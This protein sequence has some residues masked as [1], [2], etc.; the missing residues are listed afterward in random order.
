M[1]ANSEPN[2]YLVRTLTDLVEKGVVGVG[3]VDFHFN[4]IP[5]AEKAIE[6]IVEDWGWESLGRRA[7]QIRRFYAISEGDVVVAPVPYAVAIGKAAGGL[8][9]DHACFH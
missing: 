5:D 9:Y 7:N 3:W 8:F 1:K 4:D 2:Y 6:A